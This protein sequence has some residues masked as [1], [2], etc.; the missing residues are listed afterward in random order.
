MLRPTHSQGVCRI[1][2][3]EELHDMYKDIYTLLNIYLNK[4]T[5]MGWSIHKDGGLSHPKEDFSRKFQRNK[6]SR[7]TK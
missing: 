2:Y 4:E 6:A 7:K 3:H 5:H 1:R